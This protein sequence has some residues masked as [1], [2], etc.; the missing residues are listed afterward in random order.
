L[1]PSVLIIVHLLM[2]SAVAEDRPLG[3]IKGRVLNKTLQNKAVEG[4]KVELLEYGK[5]D[6]LLRNYQT[7]TGADGVFQFRD[8]PI[9]KTSTYYITTQYKDIEYFSDAMQFKEGNALAYELAVYETTD[10]GSDIHVK[11]HHIFM[12][13]VGGAIRINEAVILENTGRRVFVGIRNAALERRE[14]FRISLPGK[15]ANLQYG[16]NLARFAVTTEEGFIDTS[17]IK[18]GVKRILFSY[19]LIP[20]SAGTDYTFT[21][22]L[23][24]ETERIQFIFPDHRAIHVNSKQLKLS[25]PVEI[26][27]RPFYYLSATDLSRGTQV[28]V[29]I[30]FSKEKGV[31]RWIIPVL[32]VLVIAAGLVIPLMKKKSAVK[33]E[34][35]SILDDVKAAGASDQRDRLIHAI[36]RLDDLFESGK[37]EPDAYHTQ[38][39]ELVQK[40]KAVFKNTGT[41]KGSDFP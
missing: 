12:E 26:S 22:R 2:I 1:L 3:L 7:I 13:P 18:P 6:T 27:G 32:V 17:E 23:S 24:L 34:D 20:D 30:G 39:A 8:I 25:G 29:E 21:K 36:A 28:S 35:K 15:A 14:T 40:A 16:D 41:S 9:H 38:R 37:I 19:T 10:Q 33:G 5:E 4:L 11:M 31:F